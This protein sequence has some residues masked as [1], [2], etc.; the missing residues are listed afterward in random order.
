MEKKIR[1]ALTGNPNV[2]KTTLFNALTGSKQHVGNWPGVT[3]EKKSGKILFKGYEIEIIDLPGTYSLTAY[4]L[5]EIV[6][7]TSGALPTTERPAIPTKT[8]MQ[9]PSTL[10]IN[11][12]IVSDI[13]LIPPS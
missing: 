9:S 1:V 7:A 2:G 6:A 11:S 13:F 10:S 4:S 3:V 12:L 5:D 8:R